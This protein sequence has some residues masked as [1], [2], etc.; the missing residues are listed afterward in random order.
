M[1]RASVYGIR[2]YQRVAPARLRDACRFEPS[3][4]NYALLAIRKHGALSGWGLALKRIG[5]CRF[6]NGGVDYP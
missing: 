6:P 4:S 3:C 1:V 5:R 2:L